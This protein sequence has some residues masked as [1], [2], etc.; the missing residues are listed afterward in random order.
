[1]KLNLPEFFKAPID[2]DVVLTS[3]ILETITDFSAWMNDRKL[4]FY[5]RRET[6]SKRRCL[7]PSPHSLHAK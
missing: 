7:Q 2:T 4:P 1:M 3:C 6:K 5:M